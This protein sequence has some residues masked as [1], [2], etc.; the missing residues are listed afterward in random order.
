MSISDS[1]RVTTDGSVVSA[2]RLFAVAG[3]LPVS[4]IASSPS[5]DP[6]LR[7]SAH[8]EGDLVR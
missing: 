6:I 7:L 1:M 2:G 5:A 8:A 3:T 4:A